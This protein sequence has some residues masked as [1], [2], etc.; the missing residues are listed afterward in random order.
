[1]NPQ[2]AVQILR[3]IILLEKNGFTVAKFD[4]QGMDRIDREI[5]SL[6]EVAK[7]FLQNRTKEMV[8]LIKDISKYY[9]I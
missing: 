5:K 6:G 1:M 8:S 7:E 9:V 2:E 3:A 4:G